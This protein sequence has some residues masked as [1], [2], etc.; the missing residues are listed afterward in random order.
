MLALRPRGVDVR[1]TRGSYGRLA[2][3]DDRYLANDEPIADR[4]FR[5]IG[6]HKDRVRLGGA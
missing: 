3:C 1:R 6:A 2:T 4:L 5:W